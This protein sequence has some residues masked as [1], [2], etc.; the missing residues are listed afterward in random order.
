MLNRKA[1]LKDKHR[2]Q[3]E[4]DKTKRGGVMKKIISKIKSK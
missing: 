2:A 1:N 4:A 3:F